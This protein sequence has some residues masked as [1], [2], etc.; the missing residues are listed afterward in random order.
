[1]GS[2]RAAIIAKALVGLTTVGALLLVALNTV[3]TKDAKLR[4]KKDPDGS[5]SVGVD[6]GERRA[7]NE[8]LQECWAQD[9]TTTRSLVCSW[10]L[11][12]KIIAAD[13][14]D[15]LKHYKLVSATDFWGLFG[16]LK[17]NHVAP[18]NVPRIRNLAE[19]FDAAAPPET[20]TMVVTWHRSEEIAG[21]VIIF[22]QG[23]AWFADRLDR[24]CDVI[25]GDA[26]LPLVVEKAARF[27]APNR[28]QVSEGTFAR[29]VSH[30]EGIH[31]LPKFRS[32]GWNRLI[33]K[34][35]VEAKVVC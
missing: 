4:I 10:G 34:G 8:I 26:R 35:T 31:I 29:L 6:G 28:I 16:A 11:D 5:F 19:Y 22:P 32:R 15:S 12:K 14:L 23:D 7:L 25:V 21:N 33:G 9:P 20:R 27:P 18:A 13:D 30:T 3:N 2:P 24:T 1:M 17:T